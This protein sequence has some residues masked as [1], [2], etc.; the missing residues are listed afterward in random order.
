MAG[1][2]ARDHYDVTPSYVHVYRLITKEWKHV[3]NLLGL[4]KPYALLKT[5]LKSS[6]HRYLLT[7]SML[8]IFSIS[9][10]E[11]TLESIMRRSQKKI[12]INLLDLLA[13]FPL[14]V[15]ASI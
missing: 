14:R 6:R 1:N 4:T 3:N 11:K 9:P 13:L 15:L 7:I 5:C 10:W 8:A 12:L 2:L